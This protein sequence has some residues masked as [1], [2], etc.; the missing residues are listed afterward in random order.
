M[1]VAACPPAIPIMV[2]AGV[3]PIGCSAGWCSPYTHG[4]ELQDTAVE[5]PDTGGD[6]A[7]LATPI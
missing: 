7:E 5:F 6:A 3:S 1:L 4:R 2:W